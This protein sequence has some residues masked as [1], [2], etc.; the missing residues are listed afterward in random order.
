MQK[1]FLIVVATLIGLMLGA[2]VCTPVVHARNQGLVDNGQMKVRTYEWEFT[3]E[4]KA[5]SGDLDNLREKIDE[6]VRQELA[7]FDDELGDPVTV[8]SVEVTLPYWTE[9]GDGK[10]D[11][12]FKAVATIS[13]EF[14]ARSIAALI[15]AW[16]VTHAWSIIQ[17]IVLIVV[18]LIVVDLVTIIFEPETRHEHYIIYD[19]DGNITEEGDRIRPVYWWEDPKTAMIVAFTVAAVV[20]GLAYLKRKRKD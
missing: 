11:V 14:T 5:F 3:G 1:R 2:K 12:K 9:V 8:H 19:E 4:C 13:G 17:Y 15:I 18:L 16:V 10:Y 7:G 20:L 6:K